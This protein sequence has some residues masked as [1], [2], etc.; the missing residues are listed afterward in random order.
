MSQPTNNSMPGEYAKVS[1]RSY[2][3]GF[4]ASLVLTL[5]AYILVVHNLLTRRVLIGAVATLALAQFFSQMFF[6]L[7]LGR[8][9]KP[10]WKL[11]VFAFMVLVVAILVFGSMWIMYNLNYHMTL[12]Q[13]YQYMTNQGDGI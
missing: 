13:M 12:Q 4:A 5:S 9:T 11:L 2:V 3:I 1:L 8:E 7:H 6:F 10:R